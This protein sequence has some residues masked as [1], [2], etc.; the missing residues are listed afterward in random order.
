[1]HH[2]TARGNRQEDIFV[3]DDDREA[4]LNLL[5]KVITRY[6]WIC[7]AYCLMGNHYHL[8]IE[9]PDAN[10]SAGMR[11]LNG[12]YTQ[13]FNRAHGKVGHVFQG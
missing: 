11:Q 13:I 1:M 8:L 2:V 7:H 9:T 12:V 10:L 3:C 5:G 6:N 4:F